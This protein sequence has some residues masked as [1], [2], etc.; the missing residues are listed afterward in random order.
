MALSNLPAIHAGIAAQLATATGITNVLLKLPDVVSNLESALLYIVRP[1]FRRLESAYG[2]QA[3]EWT[4]D[5]VAALPR[6][7]NMRVEE[8]MEQIII[9][10]INVSGHDLDAH[11]TLTD[12][13]V[14][15]T[16]GR[17]DYGKISGI[18]VLGFEFTIQVVERVLYEFAN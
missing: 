10:V 6:G 17:T 13:Q 18:D 9:N 15:I 8:D 1:R 7:N 12:G 14:L 5:A 4:F 3:L 16:N 2:E 11:G